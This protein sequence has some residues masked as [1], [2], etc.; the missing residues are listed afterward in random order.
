MVLAIL[1]VQR[2]DSYILGTKAC[3]VEFVTISEGK[4]TTYAVNLSFENWIA[5]DQAS[6]W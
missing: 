3:P 6:L 5:T 2:L 4:H 1:K